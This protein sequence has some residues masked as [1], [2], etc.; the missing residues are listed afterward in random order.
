MQNCEAIRHVCGAHG[1]VA[2]N[3]SRYPLSY[4][5]GYHLE[6]E[7]ERATMGTM[8]QGIIDTG[9]PIKVWDAELMALAAELREDLLATRKLYEEA[10]R[11]NM[12]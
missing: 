8:E 6:A 4:T 5:L 7:L 2:G 12:E 9:R 3:G 10:R 1:V 11:D